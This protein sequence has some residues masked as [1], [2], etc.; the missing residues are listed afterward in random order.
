MELIVKNSLKENE[1]TILSFYGDGKPHALYE[2][3]YWIKIINRKFI[4]GKFVSITKKFYDCE[5][6][7]PFGDDYMEKPLRNRKHVLTKKG[8]EILRNVAIN[9]GGDDKHYKMHKRKEGFVK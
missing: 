5:L 2:Q 4:P 1:F 9:R 6:L 3:F 8:D 7:A